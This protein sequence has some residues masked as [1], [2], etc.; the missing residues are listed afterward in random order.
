MH[1]DC[2]RSFIRAVVLTR[3]LFRREQLLSHPNTAEEE[4]ESM[5]FYYIAPN[6]PFI[7]QFSL[8]NT[9]I[10]M[11]SS[12]EKSRRHSAAVKTFNQKHV[13]YINRLAA[14]LEKE[15][16][17]EESEIKNQN[18]KIRIWIEKNKMI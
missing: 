2:Q 13:I 6:D 8:L 5:L 4:L 11:A 7:A 12:A 9:A 16:L 15:A 17:S 10:S 3:L 18:P 1:I 14:P